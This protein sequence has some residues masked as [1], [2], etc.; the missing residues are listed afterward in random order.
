MNAKRFVSLTLLSILAF[1]PCQ[2]E[3][4]GIYFPQGFNVVNLV[5]AVDI[6]AVGTVQG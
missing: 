1:L 4:A 2:S 5:E 3:S 6:V